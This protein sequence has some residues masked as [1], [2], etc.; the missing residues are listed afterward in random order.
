MSRLTLKRRGFLL[1]VSLL[2]LI[3]L[4]VLGMGLM[5]A[6]SARYRG[7]NRSQEAAQAFQ[8]AQAGL[9]DI[10]FKLE[11]DPSFPPNPGDDQPLFNFAEDVQIGPD[12]IGSYEVL[13]D[14][15]YEKPPY[16]LIR[17]TSTG[18]VGPKERPIAQRVLKAELQRAPEEDPTKVV[19]RW[20]SFQDM[21]GI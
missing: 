11:I 14:R 6:Q 20:A 17:I 19:W 2:I 3:F 12:A 4:L 15:S 21:G 13:L 1:M 7:L 9:E 5:S 18:T 10:R 16:Q 8:L